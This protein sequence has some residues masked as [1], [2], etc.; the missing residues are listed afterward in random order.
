MEFLETYLEEENSSPPLAVRMTVEWTNGDKE[1]WLR[2]TAGVSANSTFAH[3]FG[4]PHAAAV[5][6]GAP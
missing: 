6:C 1:Q 4:T 2:R 5:S 3:G